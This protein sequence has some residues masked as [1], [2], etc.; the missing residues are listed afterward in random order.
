M[1]RRPS[2]GRTTQPLAKKDWWETWWGTSIILVVTG[3]LV[4]L[5]G[6]GVQRR[7]PDV[8]PQDTEVKQPPEIYP[9]FHQFYGPGEASP[10]QLVC[11]TKVP[12]NVSVQ[13]SLAGSWSEIP[14]DKNRGN[15]GP[16]G[17]PPGD[18]GDWKAH[19]V[20]RAFDNLHEILSREPY[21]HSNVLSANK[22]YEVCVQLPAPDE[23]HGFAINPDDKLNFSVVDTRV[24]SQIPR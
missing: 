14:P 21:L 9:T 13:V 24:V 8:K 15:V 20:V 23:G 17:F 5:I 3:L 4:W 7:Y 11:S 19:I 22:D 1:E 18:S 2:Q 10:A 12:S 16:L 6:W